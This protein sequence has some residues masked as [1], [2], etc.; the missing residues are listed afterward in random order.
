MPELMIRTPTLFTRSPIPMMRITGVTHVL[1]DHSVTVKETHLARVHSLV[2]ILAACLKRR[3]INTY[4][5][6]ESTQSIVNSGFIGQSQRFPKQ[7]VYYLLNVRPNSM[8]GRLTY[9]RANSHTSN[10]S[11]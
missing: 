7:E 4:H 8:R 5:G 1:C 10:H 6:G 9:H 3:A 11:D 2:E